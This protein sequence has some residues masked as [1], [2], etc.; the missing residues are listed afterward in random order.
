[1]PQTLIRSPFST[2]DIND[3]KRIGQFPPIP[4]FP[5]NEI[6]NR[7]V[8]LSD[9]AT[10]ETIQPIKAK[11]EESLNMNNEFM[12]ELRDFMND[13][14]G[15]E[16]DTDNMDEPTLITKEQANFYIKLFNEVVKE[17]IETEELCKSEID[18]VT[19]GITEFKDKKLSEL[20]KKK[21]YF[22]SILQQY[23]SAELEG[24][25]IKTIK[26]PYGS[27]S[28][29]KQQP[30]Y[31]YAADEELVLAMK[32]INPELITTKIT[33]SVNKA[34]LKKEGTVKDGKLFIG[35][36]ELPISVQEQDHKFEI[37]TAVK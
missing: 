11:E 28:F 32:S 18:R 22:S 30:K 12:S 20:N 35:D 24:K 26:L 9:V 13:F 31:I 33:E 37:K 2:G 8:A 16:L 36:K 25:K 4:P 23:A 7:G 34:Q 14:I 3:R 5:T 19:R 1:M 10:K 27:V 29:K 6:N 15:T 17:E 21:E